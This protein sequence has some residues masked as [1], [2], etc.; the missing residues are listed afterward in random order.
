MIV[1][2]ADKTRAVTFITF[3]SMKLQNGQN[4]NLN[5][6][7]ICTCISTV[8]DKCATEDIWFISTYSNAYTLIDV[9]KDVFT[10]LHHIL[11]QV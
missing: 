7:S 5:V 1:I 2:W 3:P 8:L 4:Q 11:K 10:Y 6:Q 9:L